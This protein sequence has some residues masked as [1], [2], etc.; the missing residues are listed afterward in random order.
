[1][2]NLAQRQLMDTIILENLERQLCV[3]VYLILPN[4]TPLIW[5]LLGDTLDCK[6]PFREYHLFHSQTAD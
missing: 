2:L 1:M 6:Y 5:Y 4:Y 3:N